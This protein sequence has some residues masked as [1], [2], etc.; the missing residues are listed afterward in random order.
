MLSPASGEAAFAPDEK[1]FG[2][3][4]VEEECLR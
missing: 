4:Y 2:A 3:F 1:E